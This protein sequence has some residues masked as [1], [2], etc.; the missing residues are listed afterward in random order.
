M[1]FHSKHIWKKIVSICIILL[2]DLR[3]LKSLVFNWVPTSLPSIVKWE[4]EYTDMRLSLLNIYHFPAIAFSSMFI[5][6]I[7]LNIVMKTSHTM[8]HDQGNICSCQWLIVVRKNVLPNG[9]WS[10]KFMLLSVVNCCYDKRPTQ[11]CMIREI[12]ANVSG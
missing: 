11:L 8:M 7:S 5:G 12:Y 4:I 1:K 9:A 3:M 2:F 6:D 10:G